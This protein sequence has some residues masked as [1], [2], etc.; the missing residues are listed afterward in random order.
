MPVWYR[1]QSFHAVRYWDKAATDDSETAAYT[2]GVLMHKMADGRFIIEHIER[3]RWSALDREERIKQITKAD[4]ER[5]PSYEVIV[6]QEPG[7]GGKESAE[8]TVRHLAGYRVSADRVTGSKV[9]RAQPF[10]AQVQAGNVWLVAGD[11][12]QAFRDECERW[13]SVRF[14]DQ[15]DAA[16]GAFNRLAPGTAFSTNYDLWAF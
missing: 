2:A 8:H 15:V 13:P 9:E 11:W 16:V 10:A 1:R 7:S 6:E 4:A 5:C 3:G 12:V 14:K